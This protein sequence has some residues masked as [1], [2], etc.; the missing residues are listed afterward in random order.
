M[1]SEAWQK[2]CHQQYHKATYK[3]LDDK[4]VAVMADYREQLGLERGDHPSNAEHGDALDYDAER[5]LTMVACYIQHLTD[6]VPF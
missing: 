1:N 5:E 4:V 6:R 3:F 2:G